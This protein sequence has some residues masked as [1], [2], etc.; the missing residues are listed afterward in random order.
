MQYDVI[1]PAAG[2]GK[3]M[4]A[5]RNKLLLE[6]SGKPV[7]IHTLEVFEKDDACRRILLAIKEEERQELESL[8]HHY[9]ITKVT[10]LLTGGSERQYSVKSCL[11]E[12]DLSELVLVH[13]GAR[14]F[15]HTETIHK[16]VQQARVSGAAVAGVKVKDTLKRVEG[17]T[18]VETVDR[19]SMV[20]IQTPQAFQTKLLQKAHEVAAADHFLGTDE[21]MLV[22][23][24]GTAV[25]VVEASYDNIKLTT[26]ED[27]LFG[28]AILRYRAQEG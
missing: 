13:D 12:S 3:R 17:S 21:S 27:L 20:A 26:P 28:E 4:G 2:S 1:I 16:L 15:I 8:L 25:S 11:F 5:D 19:E 10:K 14:P 22:E 7:L 23:R 9:A 24:I 18:I 6:L